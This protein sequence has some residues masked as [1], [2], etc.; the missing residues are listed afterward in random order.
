MVPAVPFWSHMVFMATLLLVGTSTALADEACPASAAALQDT[1]SELQ[2][3][4]LEIDDEALARSE[5]KLWEALACLSDQPTPA[6]AAQAHIALA[7][8]SFA[9]RSKG[10][11]R[12]RAEALSQTTEHLRAAQETDPTSLPQLCAGLP[13]GH[14]VCELVR[15]VQAMPVSPRAPATAPHWVELSVDGRPDATLPAERDAITLALYRDRVCWSGLQSSETTWDVL[16][17]CRQLRQQRQAR[18]FFVSSGVTGLAAVGLLA[19]AGPAVVRRYQ[20]GWQIDQCN[21][22]CTELIADASAVHERYQAMKPVFVAGLASA[23]VSGGL[24]VSGMV[25]R[26]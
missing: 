7:L 15:D 22:T 12:W 6:Q 19:S 10:D 14:P 18:A 23:A 4:F 1:A 24:L 13:E 9:S 3:A 21:Y 11:E 17:G 8:S 5:A 26:W 25:L 20:V 2:R 16:Q